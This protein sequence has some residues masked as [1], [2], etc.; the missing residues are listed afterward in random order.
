MPAG[1][2]GAAPAGLGR[3]LHSFSGGASADPG[4]GGG[5]LGA[6]GRTPFSPPGWEAAGNE[7]PRGRRAPPERIPSRS[8]L[9]ISTP[10]LPP[11]PRLPHPRACA[12]RRGTRKKESFALG[13]S[14]FLPL[15]RLPPGWPARRPALAPVGGISLLPA[16]RPPG[17]RALAG[18]QRGPPGSPQKI[19]VSPPPISRKGRI[20]PPLNPLLPPRGTLQAT[21]LTAPLGEN[22]GRPALLGRRAWVASDCW[23]I[24]ERRVSRLPAWAP[25]NP[26]ESP[27]RTFPRSPKWIHA[28]LQHCPEGA[29][30]S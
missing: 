29:A 19:P 18:S 1:Q 5:T 13:S 12:L 27:C 20:S 25:R 14:D 10:C 11:S 15:D 24:N 3:A 6:G 16:R 26:L 2:R 30:R 21:G 8:R 28:S 4:A 9:L 22:A 17:S 23:R 7:A